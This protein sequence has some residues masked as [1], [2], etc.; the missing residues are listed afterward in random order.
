MTEAWDMRSNIKAAPGSQGTLFRASH[1]NLL[2]P[3]QRWPRGYT[4]QRQQEVREALPE[5]VATLSTD[6]PHKGAPLVRTSL[7]E[8]EEEGRYARY[9][10][11][12]A[13]IVDVLARSTMPVHEIAGIRRI[14]NN[15]PTNAAGSYRPS[16]GD[17]DIDF[18]RPTWPATLLHEMGHHA[19]NVNATTDQHLETH[20]P[21]SAVRRASNKGVA[22]AIADN[23]MD[24]HYVP[25]PRERKQGIQSA[26]DV[27]GA[28]YDRRFT[29]H[30]LSRDYHGYHDVRPVS[31]EGRN[32]GPQFQQL[33][34]NDEK[35]RLASEGKWKAD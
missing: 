24:Q 12:Q 2:N 20:Y 11:T 4:P 30:V 1:P 16:I 14:G 27:P 35:L 15:P 8:Q 7:Q 6:D 32:L 21:D 28:G 19:D 3:R 22:E 25:H 29:E 10:K 17:L 18:Q 23:Y 5:A 9:P 33:T 31:H 26:A 13:A 34:I